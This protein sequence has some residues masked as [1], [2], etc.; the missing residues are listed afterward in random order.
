[1]QAC[2]TPRRFRP[3]VVITASPSR[4]CSTLI[5]SPSPISSAAS[6][7][8]PNTS[9]WCSDTR[10]CRATASTISPRVISAIRKSIG[11]C[12]TRTAPCAPANSPNTQARAAKTPNRKTSQKQAKQKENNHQHFIGPAVPIPAPREV[13]EALEQVQVQVN[14]GDNQNNNKHTNTLSK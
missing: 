2:S 3:I 5:K 6:C 4:P 10:S 7:R 1:M 12:A 13:I 11:A 8:L 9:A 14:G